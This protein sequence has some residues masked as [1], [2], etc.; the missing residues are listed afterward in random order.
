[1][2]DESFDAVI[3]GGGNKGL[4]LALY[5]I[6][7]GGM[8][9]GIFE[10]RHEIG[11]CLC[12]EE[13]S[14][15]GFRGN[16][17]ANT[18]YPWYYAP[19]FRDFPQLWD[20]GIQWDQHL[21]SDGFVFLNNET[22]LGIY[23]DKH[24]P[25]QERTAREIARFS[26]RDAEKWLKMWNLEQ[27]DTWQRVL[28]DMLFMPPEWTTREEVAMRQ[29]EV[30]TR[31]VEAG[32]EPTE[33]ILLGNHLHAATK[34]FESQELQSCILRWAVSSV[35]DINEPGCGHMAMPLATSLPTLGFNRGG[36]HQ[37]AHAVHQCLVQMGCK[38]FTHADV[39][40][41][42]IEDGTATGIQLRDGSQIK[43][44]KLVV[45]AGL[46]PEQLCFEIIGE[47]YI[48][49]ELA[50]RVRNLERSFG[51]IM[52]YIFAVHEAPKLQS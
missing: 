6:K 9:V 31:T 38:F 39:E 35:N 48:K 21:C 29:M 15:P 10:R 44:N 11:G 5:L 52:W 14:A 17:H 26:E 3:I 41:A 33:D 27:S 20:Y 2:A 34:W 46:S 47:E 12:T 22:A 42:I 28:M 50:N 45:S 7:Y 13:L 51:C 32:F 1:M 16:D 23:S 25:T 19:A 37:V 40:K 24:D 30:Y 4:F 18:M 36:T 49:D 8:K 43:A